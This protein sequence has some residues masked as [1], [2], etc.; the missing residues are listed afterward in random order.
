M[1][2]QMY[3]LKEH[4]RACVKKFKDK[5]R[6]IMAMDMRMG[7]TLAA[8]HLTLHVW[9]KKNIL[10]V[11]KLATFSAFDRDLKEFFNVKIKKLK[12]GDTPR[13]G[14]WFATPQILN[15]IVYTDCVVIVDEIH[16]IKGGAQ[17]CA[18]KKL[19]DS[20]KRVILLS[21][22]LIDNRPKDTYLPLRLVHH[23][24]AYDPQ[25]V[26]YKSLAGERRYWVF[27]H[28]YCFSGKVYMRSL[29]KSI[30]T[31]NG[32]NNHEE[33]KQNLN[34]V[35]YVSVNNDTMVVVRKNLMVRLDRDQRRKYEI[36][37]EEY[38]REQRER[39]TLRNGIFQ[40]RAPVEMGKML[41]YL[42]EVKAWWAMLLIGKAW[43][44]ETS[45]NEVL[46]GGVG[47]GGRE[48]YVVVFC[49]FI[50]TR[51][52]VKELC[53]TRGIP[54]TVYNN[55]DP[56][57]VAK[58]EKQKGVLIATFGTGSFSIDL[59]KARTC[60]FIDTSWRPSVSDQAEARLRGIR[61]KSKTVFVY[62]L[63]AG[64]TVD[65][66]VRG[67]HYEKQVDIQK[68]GIQKVRAV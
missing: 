11:G 17:S 41:E 5:E 46:M 28:R 55:K 26:S 6:C 2:E 33:L 38:V 65:E 47:G 42:S 45:F 7:K 8:L 40:A 19:C 43:E 58:W 68:M 9:G 50:K 29:G 66:H 10:V 24:S 52:F 49:N 63:Y 15:H 22:T 23:R 51:N 13:S 16:T 35:A 64:D 20:V 44:A 60:L 62:R 39:G 59:T 12:K 34:D 18:L 32:L 61:Q 67:M 30:N 37:F 56:E 57:S 54:V 25:N 31:Y 36:K 53:E 4:Q 1:E 3:M 14:I 21:G 27:M 48:E